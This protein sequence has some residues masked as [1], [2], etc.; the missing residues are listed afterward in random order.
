[1]DNARLETIMKKVQELG[2]DL[3]GYK[4]VLEQAEENLRFDNSEEAKQTRDDYMET[5][6]RVEKTR[7]ELLVEAATIK[8]NQAN[9]EANN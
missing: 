4:Y 8:K 7:K 3:A 1:M 6:E 9:N 5:I 2:C